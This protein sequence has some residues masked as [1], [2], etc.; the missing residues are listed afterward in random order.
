MNLHELIAEFNDSEDDAKRAA[1]RKRL[2]D[3]KA[4]WVLAQSR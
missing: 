4:L 1:I 2:D 3:M